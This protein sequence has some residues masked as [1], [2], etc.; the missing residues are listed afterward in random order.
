MD[1]FIYTLRVIFSI[2][3]QEIILI[4]F[5]CQRMFFYELHMN[6]A[7]DANFSNALFFFT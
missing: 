1:D 4:G 6:N 3:I 5:C 7:V 2:V